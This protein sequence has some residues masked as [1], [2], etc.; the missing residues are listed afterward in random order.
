MDM[1][2]LLVH[3]N[4]WQRAA[5]PDSRKGARASLVAT[6]SSKQL[7]TVC[8]STRNCKYSGRPGS[9]LAT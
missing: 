8:E 3:D 2:V 1:N 7:Y 9:H 4:A 5:D 6:N